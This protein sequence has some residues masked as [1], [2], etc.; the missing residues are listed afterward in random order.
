VSNKVLWGAEA[1]G[2]AINR[3]PKQ[4]YYLLNKGLIRSAQRIGTQWVA[5][6]DDLQR[7]FSIAMQATS[8][9]AREMLDQLAK[10]PPFSDAEEARS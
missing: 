1:I 4:T 6:E 3:S 8:L 7:E 2:A 5:D 9:T 10:V